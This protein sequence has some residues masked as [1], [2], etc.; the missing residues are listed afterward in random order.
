M[1]Q[2]PGDKNTTEA[3]IPARH[4]LANLVDMNSTEAVHQEVVHILGLIN[5]AF[6]MEPVDNVFKF[7]VDLYEGRMPGY[8]ACNTDYHDLSHITDTYLAMARMLHGAQLSKESF[9]DREIVLGLTG[10]LLHDTG[11]IQESHDTEGTGAKYT[12]QHVMLSMDFVARHADMFHL[13]EQEI[14]DLRDMILCTDLLADIPSIEFSTPK[15][16][17]LGKI[18]ATA[19]LIA[20][21]ADRNYLE[22]LLLLY[23]EFREAEVGDY[24]D[25]FD[26][27]HQTLGFFEI[28]AKRFKITLEDTNRFMVPHFKARWGIDKNLYIRSI[29]NQR[30]FLGKI[31]KNKESV[32]RKLKRDNIVEKIQCKSDNDIQEQ[33]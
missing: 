23:Q 10:I 2:P 3:E 19:D 1:A 8:R 4:Q 20:Q 15:I 33:L 17:L 16:E 7:T 27:L 31:L 24:K 22:K 6:V 12:P 25:E 9:T 30:D 5:P 13:S 28:S 21:M 26:F 14:A 18:L 29:E 11:M 32:Y